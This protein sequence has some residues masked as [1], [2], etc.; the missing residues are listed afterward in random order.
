MGNDDAIGILTEEVRALR[1]HYDQ[2]FAR[3]DEAF[4]HVQEERLDIVSQ[5]QEREHMFQREVL[6]IVHQLDKRVFAIALLMLF[7]LGDR[8]LSYWLPTILH[9][10]LGS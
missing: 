9:F 2:A 4:A 5:L 3:L 6:E 7:S 8:L 1:T 10:L